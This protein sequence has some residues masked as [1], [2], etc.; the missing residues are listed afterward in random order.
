[1]PPYRAGKFGGRGSVFT[2]LPSVIAHLVG[3]I[4]L[5][6]QIAGTNGLL[7]LIGRVT[8]AVSPAFLA[9]TALDF[10]LDYSECYD[11]ELQNPYPGERP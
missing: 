4:T 5:P 9:A 2:D 1:M 8:S 11:F 7:R 10:Y 3:D 6:T